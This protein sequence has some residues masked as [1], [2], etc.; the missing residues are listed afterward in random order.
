MKIRA[1]WIEDNAL[2]DL[3]HVLGPIYM[4]GRY[5]LVIAENASDGIQLIMQ[6]EFDAVIVDIR[7]PPGGNQDWVTLYNDIQYWAS[8][9]LGLIILYSLLKTDES[10]IKHSHIPPWINSNKFGVFTVESEGEVKPHLDKLKV[11]VYE[12]KTAQTSTRIVLE[13]LAKITGNKKNGR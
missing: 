10:K 11:S 6:Q 12:R 9:R 4:D 1:L 8:A 7:L 2:F 13:I 5:D 3:Q